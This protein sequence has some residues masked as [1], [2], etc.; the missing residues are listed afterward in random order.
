[1][2]NV[3]RHIAFRDYMR[4]HSLIAIE[5]GELKSRLARQNPHTMAAYID[6][7]DAFV[8]EHERRAVLWANREQRAS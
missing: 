5:Y 8:K 2:Q 3:I 4:A 1:M 7:K 6:G